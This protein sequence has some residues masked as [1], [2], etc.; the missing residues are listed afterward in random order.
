MS[1]LIEPADLRDHLLPRSGRDVVTLDRGFVEL[2]LRDQIGSDSTP[3]EK[4]GWAWV[5]AF[6]TA[7][8][9]LRKKGEAAT[10]KAEVYGQVGARAGR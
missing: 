2:I 6:L 1:F 5:L 10:T 7:R 4:G 9:T 8:K 3:R